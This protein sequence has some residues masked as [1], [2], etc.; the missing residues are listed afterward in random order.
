MRHWVCLIAVGL[1]VLG[2][3]QSTQAQ[4]SKVPSSKAEIQLSFAP[5]VRKAAPAVVNVYSSRVVRERSLSPFM[6][7]PFFRR[8]FGERGFGVPRQRVQNSLG[9]GVI[10]GADGYIVTN[11]HVIRGGTEVQ[12][13]LADRREF[14]AKVILTDE[15]TDLAVLKIEAPGSK[16][17]FLKLSDSD[18]IEVG[19]LVLAIGNPFGVGQT[20]TSGIVSAL[21]RSRVGVSDFQSFIQTDAAINPGNSGG[22]LINLAGQLVGINTAIFS[23]GGGSIGIGFA[24]PSNMTRIVIDAA[25]SGGKLRRPWFGA[26]MQPVTQDIAD[27]LGFSRPSGA[28]VQSLH[29]KSPAARAGLKRGDVIVALDGREIAQPEDFTYRFSTQK[30]GGKVGLEFRRGGK[31]R[32]ASIKV[33]AAIEDPPRNETVV[34]GR[35]PFGGAKIANLSPALADELKMDVDE[36][37]VIILQTG[38]GIARR[39]GFRRGDIIVAIEDSRVD[40]VSDALE[41]LKKRRRDWLVT[42]KRNGRIFETTVGG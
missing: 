39:V 16:L 36:A 3:V 20:V 41:L 18:D 7:D 37:G 14:E 19:D 8:F 21:A 40:D 1:L 15:Q 35:N 25:R 13:V 24:V 22:A 29:P 17:P 2:T 11:H 23:R 4:T 12:V 6:N 32:K 26:Q 9:S 10:V 5:V 31:L 28:L 38:R 33:M 34:K 42:I 27:S 30:I